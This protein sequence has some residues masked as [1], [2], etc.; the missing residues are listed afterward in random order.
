MVLKVN[1]VEV[2]LSGK[3]DKDVLAYV[4]EFGY[5]NVQE[6]MKE[7]VREK[8]YGKDIHDQII[9]EFLKQVESEEDFIFEEKKD[10]HDRLKKITKRF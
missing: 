7:S 2:K 9:N 8:I 1:R 4:E 6:L 10:L 3:F 5:S